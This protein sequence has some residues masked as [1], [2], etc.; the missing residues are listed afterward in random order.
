MQLLMKSSSK[1][2]K[3]SHLRE[4]AEQANVIER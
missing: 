1:T 4:S 3:Q 2:K